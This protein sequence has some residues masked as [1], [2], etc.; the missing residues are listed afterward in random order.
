MGMRDEERLGQRQN[1][2][3]E[4]WNARFKELLSYRSEHGDCDISCSQGKLGRWVSKQRERYRAGSLA[5]DRIERLSGIGFKWGRPKP[6]SMGMRDEER[7]GQRQNK[8]DENWNARFKEL[9]SYRSEHGDCDISCSQGKLGRWVSKQRERYRA[10]SLAQDRIER[11]SGIGFKWGPRVPWET[12]FDELVRYKAKHGDCNV[13][14]RQGPLGTWVNYQR[15]D[16]K[17][18]KLSQ[19]RIDS[20]NG[21]GFEWTPPLGRS[22]KRKSHPST[23]KQ[24]STRRETVSSPGTNVNPPSVGDGA[25]GA[26]PNGFKGEERNAASVLSLKVPSKRSDHIR[27]TGSDDEVDEIGALIYDQV[28]RRRQSSHLLRPEDVP[29]KTE[30]SETDSEVDTNLFKSED[31]PIKTEEMMKFACETDDESAL[32]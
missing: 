20:L 8:H 25:R 1:K 19:D 28:M 30:E 24:P 23:R 7:L 15:F 12:R 17:K 13:P 14:Q 11:L 4:N 31:V 27:G 32:D 3:D 22:R 18:S 5:Q 21:I 26:E 29:I 10:G 2:H 6:S 9:L 16:Y